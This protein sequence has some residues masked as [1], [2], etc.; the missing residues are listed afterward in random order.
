M[1][2][3]S[4]RRREA[5][6]RAREALA[7]R[8]R[9]RKARE[10]RIEA[11]LAN[12]FTALAEVERLRAVA[13]QR[14]DKALADGERAAARPYAEACAAVQ[15]LRDLLGSNAAVAALCELRAEDVRDMLAAAPVPEPGPT[16]GSA[17][18]GLLSRLLCNAT[19]PYIVPV[20][21]RP[22]RSAWPVRV[23]IR[24]DSTVRG[25]M[26]TEPSVR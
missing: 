4:S 16:S 9:A 11:A 21:E 5:V 14:A 8:E 19:D 13:R 24:T 25:L 7:E 23:A 3:D 1:S 10:E 12:L 26:R 17:H 15:V 6:R 20:R 18:P 22:A 2:R